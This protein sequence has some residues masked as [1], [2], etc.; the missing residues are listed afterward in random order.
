M[1]Y[2]F[3]SEIRDTVNAST[4]STSTR[5][6]GDVASGLVYA[7]LARAKHL[8]RYPS[9]ISFLQYDDHQVQYLADEVQASYKRL[10]AAVN[11]LHEAVALGYDDL[12]TCL[13]R[14]GYEP[15]LEEEK[16]K[17]LL[18]FRGDRTRPEP[19]EEQYLQLFAKRSFRKVVR[20]LM[21]AR[22]APVALDQLKASAGE[23]AAEYIAFL[24]AQ[25]A[26]EDAPGGVRL[27]REVDNIGPSLEW[28]VAQLCA[29]EFHGSARWGVKLEGLEHGDYDVLA[30]LD[31]LLVYIETKSARPKDVEDN[32]IQK[33][34]QRTQQLAPDLAIFLVSS[35]R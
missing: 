14:R 21:A 25:D 9:R 35:F 33:F 18:T 5:L 1:R 10:Y 2:Y 32:Q 31:P 6:E 24:R 16:H 7:Y 4:S 17:L 12:E 13:R 26:L 15:H 8:L 22:G 30:W 19:A 11:A 20:R 28:Y 23:K 29:R 3:V 27:T 34:L